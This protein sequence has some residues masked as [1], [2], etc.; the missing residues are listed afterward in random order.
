[1]AAKMSVPGLILSSYPYLRSAILR[2]PLWCF[3][4][5]EEKDDSISGS[6]NDGGF[7]RPCVARL[8]CNDLCHSVINSLS[9]SFVQNLQDTVY[10]YIYIVTYC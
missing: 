1:M 9:H 7:Y 10:I 4:Y 6:M 8:F 5:L 3:E 2:F